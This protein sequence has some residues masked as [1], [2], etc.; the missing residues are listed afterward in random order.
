MKRR[1]IGYR[2]YKDDHSHDYNLH[3]EELAARV[4]FASCS[5]FNRL[6]D[7][8]VN[9]FFAVTEFSEKILKSVLKILEKQN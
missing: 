7:S 1:A 6:F 9:G 5:A 4:Y 2:T 8:R 3:T